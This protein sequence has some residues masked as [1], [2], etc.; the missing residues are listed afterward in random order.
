MT[1]AYHFKKETMSNPGSSV[2]STIP[3]RFW[4][5]LLLAVAV[6]SLAG[7]SGGDAKR[8][9]DA[10]RDNIEIS[11]PSG[12]NGPD[13]IIQSISVSDDTITRGQHFTL[14][15]TIRNQG[16]RQSEAYSYE[17]KASTSSPIGFSSPDAEAVSVVFGR[18]PPLGPSGIETAST[19][20]GSAHLTP[21]TY[22]YGACLRAGTETNTNNNCSEV[23]VTVRG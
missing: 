22:Y 1:N 9:V 14:S 18:N 8:I 6:L 13:L 17:F 5:C 15:I 4:A 12:G 16:N 19:S 21:G 7:C 20:A 3:G 2:G 23:R 10:I 11:P